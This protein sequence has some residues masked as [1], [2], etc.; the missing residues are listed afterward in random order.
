[1]DLD[2]PAFHQ[3]DETALNAAT[4][5]KGV[6][7]VIFKGASG[8][9][10]FEKFKL[11]SSFDAIAKLPSSF[12]G[13]HLQTGFVYI[14][15]D[16]NEVNE[17]KLSNN[18][19]FRSNQESQQW[20][21]TDFALDPM[22]SIVS[23]FNMVKKG[24]VRRYHR[25][26]YFVFFKPRGVKG[27][28]E[29]FEQGKAHFHDDNSMSLLKISSPY[30]FNQDELN[31]MGILK[32]HADIH[33]LID[34]FQADSS[35][36]RLFGRFHDSSFGIKTKV[37]L[38]TVQ[39]STHQTFS[40]CELFFGDKVV[41]DFNEFTERLKAMSSHLQRNNKDSTIEANWP[42]VFLER[43]KLV[44]QQHNRVLDLSSF[45]DP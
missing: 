2:I 7:Q 28:K 40:T 5:L 19:L 34:Q 13:N 30:R 12:D 14:C 1:M 15:L 31:S 25:D 6:L 4:T 45:T 18:L 11:L 26:F 17:I 29:Y 10:N 21:S 38:S 42:Y 23:L 43:A 20:V 27:I 37:L 33:T 39:F 41:D 3:L 36:I 32:F 9:N 22:S 35:M 24:F 8:V 16:F 44:Y